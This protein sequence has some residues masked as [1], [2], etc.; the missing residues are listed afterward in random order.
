KKNGTWLEELTLTKEVTLLLKKLLGIE[1][2]Y[3]NTAL[4]R[5]DLNRAIQSVT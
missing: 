2:E 3:Q 1:E 4:I 5:E